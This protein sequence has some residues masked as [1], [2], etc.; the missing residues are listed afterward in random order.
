MGYGRYALLKKRDIVMTECTCSIF[1]TREER[2]IE[3]DG[4]ILR[5]LICNLCGRVLDSKEEVEQSGLK[6]R[7][8]PKGAKLENGENSVGI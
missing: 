7:S 5:R 3:D 6:N 8:T 4:R 1:N 2:I